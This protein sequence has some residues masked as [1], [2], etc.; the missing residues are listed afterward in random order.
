M[1]TKVKFVRI[2]QWIST[3]MPSRSKVFECEI[4]GV[5]F[6]YQASNKDA[7]Y[8]HARR[9]NFSDFE[10]GALAEW[11]KFALSCRL[12]IDVGAYSG[13]YSLVASTAGA[14][15]LAFEPNGYSVK[16][17]KR[18]LEINQVTDYK[19]YEVALGDSESR[20]ELL[21]PRLRF[22]FKPRLTGSGVQISTSD[23]G[24]DIS[25]WQVLHS[26]E[27]AP[28][29]KFLMDEEIANAGIIKIDAEGNEFQILL[30]ATNFLTNSQSAI[31]VEC[32]NDLQL[33]SVTSKLLE[34]DYKNT[35]VFG[36]NYLFQKPAS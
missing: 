35:K 6:K 14:R 29:D 13:I 12:V 26:V 34:F 2:L 8:H 31:L 21:A 24:R 11:Q 16:N 23:S 3:S 4:N 19:L 36:K 20:D 27:V 15:V 18:N 7:F 25:S 30:G 33:G 5:K 28:L 9:G 32:L 17:L 10:H 22:H 1:N